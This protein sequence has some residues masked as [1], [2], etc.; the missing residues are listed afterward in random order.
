[1]GGMNHIRMKGNGSYLSLSQLAYRLWDITPVAIQLMFVGI[2]FYWLVSWGFLLW[3]MIPIDVPIDDSYWCSCFPYQ[4]DKDLGPRNTATLLFTVLGWVAC[5][6]AF[7]ARLEEQRTACLE[8]QRQVEA[9]HERKAGQGTLT[10]N[11]MKILFE[12]G[13]PP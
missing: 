4:C 8:L 1:M 10:A 11:C 9:A 13:G 6:M 2:G 3:T 12:C 5:H 7:Q